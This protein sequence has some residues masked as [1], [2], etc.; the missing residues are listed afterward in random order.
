MIDRETALANYYD[1]E[2][3]AGACPVTANER[4]GEFAKRLD[5]IEEERAR[6]LE[7]IKQCIGRTK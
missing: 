6:D 2:R 1:S 3:R 5:A 4:M 7:I